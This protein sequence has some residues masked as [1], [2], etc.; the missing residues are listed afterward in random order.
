MALGDQAAVDAIT[1]QI[2]LVVTFHCTNCGTVNTTPQA[3][4]PVVSQ[5][6]MVLYG[7]VACTNCGKRFLIEAQVATPFI[8]VQQTS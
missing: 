2:Q 6:A 7:S 8:T 5:T 1:G 3:T 4:K